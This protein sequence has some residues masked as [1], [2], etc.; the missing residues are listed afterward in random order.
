MNVSNESNAVL[1]DTVHFQPHEGDDW[2]EENIDSFFPFLTY[3]S[4]PKMIE[5]VRTI[6]RNDITLLASQCLSQSPSRLRQPT[7]FRSGPNVTAWRTYSVQSA[8]SWKK[9]KVFD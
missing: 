4:R 7:S 2:E 1:D 6:A 9:D 8:V 5:P 3:D